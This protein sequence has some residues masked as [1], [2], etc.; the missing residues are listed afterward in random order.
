M[1]LLVWGLLAVVSLS[2]LTRLSFDPDML[3]LFPQNN[4]A[5]NEFKKVIGEMGTIDYHVVVIDI[6]EGHETSDYHGY[7]DSMGK[8]WS[9]STLT[10]D[11]VYRVPNPIDMIDAVLPRAMLLLNED[12]IER[13]GDALTDE[14]IREAVARNRALLQTPL[15]PPPESAYL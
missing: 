9:R 14:R 1:I 4:K 6:P 15:A 10:E 5:V 7:I 13:V 2:A 12:E 3:N 11:V 8:A